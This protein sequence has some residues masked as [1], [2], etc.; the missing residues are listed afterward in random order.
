MS[1]APIDDVS[2]TL[3]PAGI[4]GQPAAVV[5]ASPRR[6]TFV[7]PWVDRLPA[8]RRTFLGWSVAFVL[9]LVVPL[10]DRN[11]GDI[12][13]FANAGT[14]V[15]LA[16]GLNIVVGFTGLLDLG[17]AAFFA[18]GAYTYGLAASF[19]LKIPWSVL[20]IP[21][22][23]LGQVSQVRFGTGDVAQLHFSYWVVLPIAAL[24]CAGFGLLFGTPTLRLRG[25]YLAIVTLGFGEIVP[26]V[27]RNASTITNG[28][29]GL[30]G[31]ATPTLFGFNFGFVSWPYYYLIVGLVAVMV[32][33]SYRLQFSRTGRAWLALREDE[34][35]AGPMGID[36]V[37]YKLLA[38]AIGAG[39]GGLAGTF[40]VAKLTTATPD[41]FQ[42][43]VSTIILVMVVLGGLGSI[44]GVVAGALIL[45][46]F[47]SI[48]L[49]GLNQWAHGLGNMTGLVVLKTLDL[50]Q[51][52]QLI[53][54][55][56]LVAM[57]L[58]RRQ[59]LIPA[60]RFVGALSI[61]DQT[62]VAGRGGFKPTFMICEPDHTVQ[63]GE[64]LL[65]VKGLVK[66]FGGL[67][68]ADNIDLIAYPGEIVSVIGPN[69]S[70]KTTL[71][72]M[73]TGL[74]RPDSG[75]AMYHGTDLTRLPP[76]K[77]A[78]I[79]VTR[80]FQNLRLFNNLS[81]MENV[82]I[83]QHAQLHEGTL[84][85]VLRTPNARHEEARALSWGHD[86]L[87]LFG[88]R[89][90]PRLDHVVSS[91]SY[92]NRRRTEI[93]RALAAR[94]RLL[95]LDE[96]AAGMNPAETLELMDQ[97]RSLKDLGVTVLL[98]EHKMELVNTISDRVI[99]LDYGKKIAEGSP[100]AI[101]D[102]PLVIEAYLGKRRKRA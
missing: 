40:H 55:V 68:A 64:P 29:Q 11:G 71:F 67:V 78:S 99:V 50:T 80:T 41:M 58:Y 54:G 46:I 85:S 31:V 12:D 47:Q 72:N 77:I 18:L 26:I 25:D 14:Y 42:F 20:W 17:Y 24:I 16:L 5:V 75:T 35:A 23:W 100:A 22:T 9:L 19:Q 97:I 6:F 88:N 48:I 74:V 96:P 90:M 4:V 79:G 51:A 37:H 38:F 95:L 3:Q 52:N 83:G 65:A 101:Q 87:G 98:V 89:L 15:L 13:G 1:T 59:G 32:F 7:L 69:G 76:H 84:A 62:V 49:G 73:L 56:V 44:P 86:I 30:P 2:D 10:I 57:M 27:L 92:A 102:D 60:R 8:S 45:T 34:L 53:Y 70:G 28:A 33:M 94:P 82:L 81:V 43:T 61:S 21:F 39:I 66:R 91:L 36:H 93:S 63:P